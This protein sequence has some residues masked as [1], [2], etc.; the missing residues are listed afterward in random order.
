MK[1]I[2][3]FIGND[4]GA[5]AI[6]YALTR[7]LDPGAGRQGGRLRFRVTFSDPAFDVLPL[8][9]QPAVP[10]PALRFYVPMF[11]CPGALPEKIAA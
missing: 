8:P 4:D 5:T 7:R 2:K 9:D 11:F 6:E 1:Q 3:T 10:L